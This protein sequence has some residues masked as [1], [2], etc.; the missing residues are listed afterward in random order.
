MDASA[1]FYGF[2]SVFSK[3]SAIW[4]PFVFGIINAVSGSSR[5]A[6]ISLIAFFNIPAR[7]V[8]VSRRFLQASITALQTEVSRLHEERR[9]GDLPER[10]QLFLRG[11]VG[12]SLWMAAVIFP[13][14]N[15]SSRPSLFLTFMSPSPFTPSPYHRFSWL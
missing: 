4:G 7:I 6:I 9:E 11:Q 13:G 5:Q 8:T 12:L 3:F 15:A 14:S 2:Y 1:E 10:L